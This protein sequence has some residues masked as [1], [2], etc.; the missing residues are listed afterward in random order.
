MPLAS[1]D[2]DIISGTIVFYKEGDGSLGSVLLDGCC[3]RYKLAQCLVCF[4]LDGQT[5]RNPSRR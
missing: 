4:E 2:S 5:L 3:A 1:S